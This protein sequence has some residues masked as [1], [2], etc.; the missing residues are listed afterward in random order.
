LATFNLGSSIVEVRYFIIYILLLYILVQSNHIVPFMLAILLALVGAV[1]FAYRRSITR[2]SIRRQLHIR[3]SECDDFAFHCCLPCCSITQEAREASI[4]IDRRLDLIYEEELSSLEFPQHQSNHL[5]NRQAPDSNSLYE[6][7]SL[8][9]RLK[10]VSSA[11]RLIAAL[12]VLVALRFLVS[13]VLNGKPLNIVVLVLVFAQPLLVLYLFYWRYHRSHASLDYVIKLFAVGFFMSTIQSVVF[14]SILEAVLGVVVL[15]ILLLM[16][17]QALQ[18]DKTADAATSP[19]FLQALLPF[20]NSRKDGLMSANPALSLRLRELIHSTVHVMHSGL[21]VDAATEGSE[22]SQ[23]NGDLFR[24]D[25]VR[26]NFPLVVV[27]LLVMSFV[28]AAGVEETMKHFAIRCCRFPADLRDPHSVRIYLMT[29]ALG[30]AT[31]ENI[32]YVFDK[33]SS[34]FTG[35]SAFESEL[36]ILLLRIAM[37]VHVICSVLQSITLSKVLMGLSINKSIFYVS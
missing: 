21:H 12:S 28:I 6:S 23:D 31:A 10:T 24:P 15:V 16:D 30:F 9:A 17:P 7:T 32:E 2:T 33:K 27:A 25:V 14:E 34:S 29:A 20:D 35:T 37:P 22:D 4:K 13:L 8:L 18:T 26:K 36:L 1:T 3:G 5:D 19:S 11:S